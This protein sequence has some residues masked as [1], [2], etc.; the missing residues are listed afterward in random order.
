[1]SKAMAAAVE[2]QNMKGPLKLMAK[3][4]TVDYGKNRP[5]SAP[6][7][8]HDGASQV[9]SNLLESMDVKPDIDRF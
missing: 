9:S 1:M 5:V 6:F 3:A 8:F 7:D 2:M 4:A